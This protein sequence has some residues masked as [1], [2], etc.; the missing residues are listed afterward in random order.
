[1]GMFESMFSFAYMMSQGFGAPI[2]NEEAVKNFLKKQQ[3]LV[4]LNQ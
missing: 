3:I 2:N 1:M 4:I